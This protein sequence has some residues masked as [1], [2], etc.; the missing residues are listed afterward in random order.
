MSALPRDRDYLGDIAEAAE[1]ILTYIVGLTLE[2][3]LNDTPH[4][5]HSVLSAS[6]PA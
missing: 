3:F 6:A 2:S 4:P 5:R 1:R